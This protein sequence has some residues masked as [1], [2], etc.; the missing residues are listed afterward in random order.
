M[1]PL[2]Q[3]LNNNPMLAQFEQFRKT[4]TGDPKQQVQAMLNNG[5]ITQEQ[6][7]QLA[8]QAT[9]LRKLIR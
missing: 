9:Q 4:F 7:N 6:L 3:L 1:N 5:Q 2:Y 8:Q